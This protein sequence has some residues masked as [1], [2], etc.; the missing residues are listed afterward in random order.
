[1][2]DNNSASTPP[3]PAPTAP[4]TGASS[5]SAT[6]A[7]S[8]G[9][10][11]VLKDLT[12]DSIIIILVVVIMIVIILVTIYIVRLFK[13]SN[14]KETKITTKIVKL[15]DKASMPM[16]IPTTN[17]SVSNRGQEFTYSFWI[18]LGEYTVTTQHK[19]IFQRGSPTPTENTVSLTSTANPIIALDKGTNKLWFALSTTSVT[20]VNSLDTIFNN[21]SSHLVSKIDYIPLHR[22]VF[23]T[24]VLRDNVMTIYMDGDIYSVSTTS[25]IKTQTNANRPIV[26]STFGDA[27]IGSD[28]HF[29]TSFISKMNIYNY[30]LTQK[31]IMKKYNEGPISKSLLSFFGLGNYGVRTPIFKMEDE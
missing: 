14:L 19:L 12:K 20:T 29:T 24:Q 5:S 15:H 11:G 4:E 21:E 17:M 7:P 1:M 2:S 31:D 27:F 22:W 8:V 30:A 28:K 10:P 16:N 18:Y 6:S 26:S 13:K 25:S 23:V 3:A 9:N